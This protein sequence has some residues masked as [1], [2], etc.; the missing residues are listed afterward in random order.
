MDCGRDQL[1][2]NPTDTAGYQ[3]AALAVGVSRPITT[4]CNFLEAKRQA[5]WDGTNFF[6]GGLQTFNVYVDNN[7]VGAF[8]PTST[9]FNSFT[10]N[11]I[12]LTTGNH[13]IKF[14]GT[15]TSGDNTDFIDSVA[16]IKY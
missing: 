8:S 16:M 12:A 14:E 1:A 10:S 6:Y 2:K 7:F 9:S 4:I 13:T 11:T 5:R 3:L 15:T